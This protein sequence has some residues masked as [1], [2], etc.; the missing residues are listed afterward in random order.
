MFRLKLNAILL[1]SLNHRM[2][3]SLQVF[4]PKRGI[5][6]A[7][8][9]LPNGCQPFQTSYPKVLPFIKLI[10]FV[11]QSCCGFH[12]PYSATLTAGFALLVKCGATE[13]VQAHKQ[14]KPRINEEVT[15][16]IIRKIV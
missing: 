12:V 2:C 16:H 13:N 5:S 1:N 3:C 6:Q 11:Q 7:D 15:N 8:N 14:S 4:T 10:S 9:I